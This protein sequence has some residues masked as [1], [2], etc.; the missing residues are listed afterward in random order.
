LRIDDTT[1]PFHGRG[2]RDH[3]WGP[4]PWNMEWTFLVASNDALRVQCVEVALPDLPR[5]GVGYL[6]RDTTQSLTSVE[7]PFTMD[8]TSAARPL[9]GRFAITAEDG[10]RFAARVEP[11][12]AAEIDITH[13]FVPPARSIYRRALIRV[14]PDDGGA[15]LVGW[16]E[17][18]YFPPKR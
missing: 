1:L 13:T 17:F 7:I 2:E 8:E 4:R 10:T 15:P 5:F 12:A 14:H 6:H 18:N 9:A 11:I 16:S 3:S